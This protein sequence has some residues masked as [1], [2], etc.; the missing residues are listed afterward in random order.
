MFQPP[1]GADCEHCAL[2]A[3][4]N[5]VEEREPIPV[6]VTCHIDDKIALLGETPGRTETIEGRNFCG[7]CGQEVLQPALEAA[8]VKRK[9]V[10]ILNAAACRP[11][12]DQLGIIR[13]W[14]KGRGLRDPIDAC[15]GRMLRDLEGFRHVL[16][17]GGEAAS[18]VRGKQTSIMAMHG[19]GEERNGV[20]YFYSVH[21]AFVLRTPEWPEVFRDG[22]QKGIDWFTK[23]LQPLKPKKLIV[24][25]VR[26]FDYACA[27]WDPDEELELDVETDGKDPMT[28]RLRCIGIG[29]EKFAAI[30]PY[31]SV[32]GHALWGLNDKALFDAVCT[33]ILKNAHRLIGHNAN[34]YDRQV[35]LRYGMDFLFKHDT[36]IEHLLL[37]DG[38]RHRLGFLAAWRTPML[39][40]WKADHVALNTQSDIELW[41]YNGDDIATGISV[42]KSLRESLKTRGSPHLEPQEN[43]LHQFGVSMQQ[44]GI[45]VDIDE[46]RKL[47]R[48]LAASEALALANVHKVRPGLNP[49]SHPQLQKLFFDQWNLPA[50]SFSAKTGNESA[51]EKSLRTWLVSD[52]LDADQEMLI[53]GVLDCR[54]YGKL[55]GTYLKGILDGT[56]VGRDGR[57]HASYNRLPS[58]GRYNSSDPNFQN[59]PYFVR[60]IYVPEEGHCFVYA[61]ESQLELRL[62]SEEAGEDIVIQMVLDGLDLHNESMELTYGPEVWDLSGA[63]SDRRGKATEGSDFDDARGIVKNVGYAW[64]YGA[65][66]KTVRDQVSRVSVRDNKTG[67]VSYPYA[68]RPID[69]IR[70]AMRARAKAFPHIPRW[71]DHI[72]DFYNDHGYVE[73]PLWGR[74]RY[75]PGGA[76]R[77]KLV[78]PPIQAGGSA[79]VHE[80]TMDLMGAQRYI[81]ATERLDKSTIVRPFAFDFQERVGVVNQAHDALLLEVSVFEIEEWIEA[82]TV[83]MSRRRLNGRGMPY[84]ADAK[85]QLRWGV[86]WAR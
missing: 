15:R 73:D 61:D 20:K 42:H 45:R 41:S 79:L 40:A 38:L 13:T 4:Y 76:E 36:L 32:K 55:R 65:G 85:S 68:T 23:K 48:E 67:I 46:A 60:R 9:N 74:K 62:I 6:L 54:E 37:G 7:K 18:A 66:L 33:W 30:I 51:D 77:S 81:F 50:V 56:L 80:A 83:C 72:E 63:P 21:P 71:W 44:L 3:W 86:K 59:Q 64:Q 25:N 10:R 53:R 22:I 19:C 78:N 84:N 70:D 39:D 34:H 49:N 47:D 24:K 27:Q 14:A 28:C 82:L 43:W 31:R 29:N 26:S 57:V 8:H 16:V 11:P 52:I 35:L 1:T 58:S 17:M 12:E 75:Y 69:V 5:K 2:R